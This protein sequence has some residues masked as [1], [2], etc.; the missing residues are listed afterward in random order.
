MLHSEVLFA[1]VSNSSG[2]FRPSR[3]AEK[4]MLHITSVE[5]S[6]VLGDQLGGNE[7]S[8]CMF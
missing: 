1:V 8:Y 4:L 3:L 2:V 5:I 7:I 6:A